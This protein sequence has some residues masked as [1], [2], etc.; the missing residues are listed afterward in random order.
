MTEMN[1]FKVSPES[2]QRFKDWIETNAP[3][4]IFDDKDAWDSWVNSEADR[5]KNM[6]DRNKNDQSLYSDSED[7]FNAFS[8][9]RD[10]VQLGQL[11]DEI[12][13]LG[14]NETFV[15]LLEN[16]SDNV[17]QT[18]FI[19]SAFE[20]ISSRYPG[21]SNKKKKLRKKL[22]SNAKKAR[23]KVVKNV[24]LK[25]KRDLRRE[26]RKRAENLKKQVRLTPDKIFKEKIKLRNRKKLREDIE[27]SVVSSE[28][29][30]LSKRII[31]KAADTQVKEVRSEIA[32]RAQYE[33][34]TDLKL[35]RERKLFN[36][37]SDIEDKMGT[38]YKKI[39]RITRATPKNI[40]KL[41]AVL[42]GIKS[43]ESRRAKLGFR[44]MFGG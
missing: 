1:Y 44:F 27:K 41:Q 4:D 15:D 2:R 17:I 24:V 26:I 3:S 14:K 36:L 33:H 22:I 12:N 31:K 9:E 42:R 16:Q 21:I 38:Q 18:S 7:I 37:K 32:S 23:V 19:E 34:K 13:S 5:V 10:T 6:Y 20:N 35:S 11:R 40:K 30:R 8:E 28:Y 43:G 29:S 25:Q 39:D